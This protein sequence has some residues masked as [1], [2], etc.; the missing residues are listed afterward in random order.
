MSAPFD[1]AQPPFVYKSNLC[2]TDARR[3][4]TSIFYTLSFVR[5]R[6]ITSEMNFRQYEASEPPIPAYVASGRADSW[7]EE[8]RTVNQTHSFTRRYLAYYE[9]KYLAKRTE[10][11]PPVF[12]FSPIRNV[13]CKVNNPYDDIFG[14]VS[15]T[16]DGNIVAAPWTPTAALYTA[17]DAAEDAYNAAPWDTALRDAYYAAEADCTAEIVAHQI[18][19]RGNFMILSH[20]CCPC[21]LTIL[22]CPV[23]ITDGMEITGSYFT[24]AKPPSP[25][26]PSGLPSSSG[27]DTPTYEDVTLSLPA[28]TTN[29]CKNTLRGTATHEDDEEVWPTPYT[30]AT[31]TV[32]F[33]VVGD[34][35][36]DAEILFTVNEAG[37]PYIWTDYS[38]ESPDGDTYVFTLASSAGHLPI[39]A[40]GEDEDEQEGGITVTSINGTAAYAHLLATGE[41]LRDFFRLTRETKADGHYGVW[42]LGFI[43]KFAKQEVNLPTPT[44]FHEGA[45]NEKMGI[46]LTHETL[47]DHIVEEMNPEWEG[48]HY[49]D[50][51]GNPSPTGAATYPYPDDWR[52]V[53]RCMRDSG[54]SWSRTFDNTQSDYVVNPVSGNGTTNNWH[55][56]GEVGYSW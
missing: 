34:S 13:Q 19:T 43:G 4:I 47:S 27:T 9:G 30:P 24:S 17:R 2:W 32:S 26:T 54:A 33:A 51:V 45:Y 52:E 10:G 44:T 6:R 12:T 50:P 5:T 48:G 21:A 56:V 39:T 11:S 31:I 53:A 38:W 7:I 55:R 23:V 16:G 42:R 1:L 8:V 25:N 46:Q 20:H 41:N 18:W 22:H 35:T 37:Q 49:Y 28:L 14:N 40:Y 29:N 36:H 3:S 15:D